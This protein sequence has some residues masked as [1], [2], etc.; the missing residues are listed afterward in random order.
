MTNQDIQH[1]GVTKKNAK[2]G[3]GNHDKRFVIST[4]CRPSK[5]GSR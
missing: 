5:A 2:Q 4:N 3:I 1:H